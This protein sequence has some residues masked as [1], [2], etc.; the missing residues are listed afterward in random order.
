MNIDTT[1]LGY[2][3][4]D[5]HVICD[6]CAEGNDEYTVEI[7]VNPENTVLNPYNTEGWSDSGGLTCDDCHEFLVE[8]WEDE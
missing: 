4:D 7:L 1:I 3:I 6:D 5:C 8:P 2:I